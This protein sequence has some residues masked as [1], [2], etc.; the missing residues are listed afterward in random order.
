MKRGTIRDVFKV[1]CSG[2]F[3]Y[4]C[5]T[6]CDN[7]VESG[8]YGYSDDYLIYSKVLS[9]T[10]NDEGILIVLT[11]STEQDSFI[12]NNIEYYLERF[13]DAD[14]GT[15]ENYITANQSKSKLCRIPGIKFVFQSDYNGSADKKVNVYLSNVGYNSNKTEAFVS[16]GALYA[17]LVGSGSLIFLV[18]I[19]NQWQIQK[20]VMTWIS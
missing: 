9:E 14:R 10:I 18:K 11:D 20:R 16:M 17:P 2:L 3:L 5:L 15:L 13:P 19:N 6:S 1:L 7:S 4:S 8:E 12:Q